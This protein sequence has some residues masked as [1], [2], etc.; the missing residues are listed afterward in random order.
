[1]R[2]L[3][4]QA[5]FLSVPG[6]ILGGAAL[7]FLGGESRNS[8]QKGA[9]NA[10]MAF[11]EEMSNTAVQ[12]RMADMRAGGINPILAANSAGSTPPG[13]Q[14]Q[15]MDTLTPAVSTAIQANQVQANVGVLEQKV[16]NLMQEQKTSRSDEW[17][18]DVQRALSSVQYNER[19]V[20]VDMLKEQ[21][22]IAKRAGEVAETDFGL[23]MRY[24]GEA[25]G[26][27]GNIFSGSTNYRIN[28]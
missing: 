18:K 10:Q 1:M 23:Y 13:A 25:T 17:L 6:A 7:S 3:K 2:S 8:A 12:R 19:L 22:K 21:L 15:I 27:I 4:R 26:A 5:G 24:L 9:A 20:M 16:N 28:P 11:Q 14:P